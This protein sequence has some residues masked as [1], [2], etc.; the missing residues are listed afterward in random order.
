MRHLLPALLL[1]AAPALSAAA[2]PPAGFRAL[3]NGKDTAGWH[4]YAV[5]DAGA[6][7]ARLMKLDAHAKAEKIAAW[8]ADA[9]KHWT[10]E[11]GELVNDGKGAYLATD[12][13]LGDIELRIEYRT[14]PKA[15]SGIYLRGVPQVQIWDFTDKA[16]FPLGADKGSG[17][18]WN[19]ALTTGGKDPLVLA[20]KPLGEWNHFR[21]LQVGERTTVYLN[22]KL[23]VDHKRLDN[24]YYPDVPPKVKGK[25]QQKSPHATVV[26]LLKAAPVI[27]QT[28]G[29]EI[30]WRNIFVR[31]IP[32]AEAN[33]MLLA[34][35]TDG[36][37]PLFDGKSLAG[38]AGATADY[39]V[40]DGA[41]VCRP[42]RGGNLYTDKTF[43]D[44]TFVTEYKTPP[45][46]NNGLAIRYPGT[47]DPSV[48]G[49]CEVQVLDDTAKAYTKIDPRQANGS[50]Y[51]V[52]PAARGY[53]RPTGEWN[54]MAVTAKGPMIEVELNG[55]RI[56]AGDVSKATEFMRG[57]KPHAGLNLPSGH[58][59]F[60]GHSD[61]VEFRNV[62]I[63]ELK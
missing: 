41:I 49:M 25:G 47:G 29:G 22:D 34:K 30:R 57:G 4:G 10:V 48:T 38:W 13:D 21:I 56:T 24:Y 18:L 12:A 32:A 6:D 46:G 59:G 61:P 5:H 43:T 39:Q 33:A 53:A 36:F 63:K 58:V 31:D 35:M 17:G 42:K 19:N 50:V 20:D 23:V 7:P 62:R 2:D 11:N 3:F 55:T 14:V 16:K 45:A 8:T 60:A 44:F 1:L 51:G 28:H 15:D 37:T 40:K 26:P 54:V 27:L 52:F 9:L